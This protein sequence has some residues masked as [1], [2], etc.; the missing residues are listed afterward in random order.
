MQ[1]HNSNVIQFQARGHELHRYF[2]A[3]GVI[4]GPYTSDS[5]AHHDWEDSQ[6]RASEGWERIGAGLAILIAFC[7]AMAIWGALTE[8][9]DI[10]WTGV[11]RL[12]GVKH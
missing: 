5:Q 3:P 2:T 7:V 10:D 12:F 6:R 4:D 8:R 11:A 1:Q 9:F